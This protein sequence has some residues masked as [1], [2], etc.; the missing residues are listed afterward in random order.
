MKLVMPMCYIGDSFNFFWNDWI[1][2]RPSYSRM[3]DNYLGCQSYSIM[4]SARQIMLNTSDFKNEQTVEE[5]S[6]RSLY[7]QKR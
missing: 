6:N 1:L 7:S 2:S 5:C 4:A 3:K